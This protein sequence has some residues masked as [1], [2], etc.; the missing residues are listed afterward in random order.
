[1]PYLKYITHSNVY[2]FAIILLAVSLPVSVFGMSLAQ[3]ILVINWV[4]EGNFKHKLQVV[5]G[6]KTIWIF[7]LV[8]LVHLIG[9]IYTSWPEGFIG[10]SYNAVKDIRIKLPIL[11]LPLIIGTSESLSAK[12][13]KTILLLF[14]TVVTINSFISIS[15]LFGYTNHIVNDIRDISLFISHIRFALLINIAIFSLCYYLIFQKQVLSKLEKFLF[16][17]LIIW[18]LVFLFILQSLTGLIILL[19]CGY[20]HIVISVFFSK[21]VIYKIIAISF[22]VLLPV[23]LFISSVAVLQDFLTIDEFNVKL[24]DKSTIKGSPYKH[25]T[26]NLQI[27][28]G[29]WVGSYICEKELEESWNRISDFKYNGKDRKGQ[30][31]KYTLI[32]YLTSMNLRKDT[33]GVNALD[34]SDIIMIEDG[35]SNFIFKNKYSLYPRIYQTIWEVDLYLRGGS[36]GGHSVAQRIEYLKASIGIIKQNIWFGVGTGDAQMAFNNQY[37]EMS[38]KLKVEYRHRA[39]NQFVTFVIT[40]GLIGAII[41]LFAMFYPIFIEKGYKDFLFLTFIIIAVFSML[42]EDTLETQP[43]VSFFAFFYSLFLFSKRKKDR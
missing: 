22:V 10:D 9:L 31:T 33:E 1:M 17:V 2:Y 35:Y 34:K 27:E 32:R 43:G 20:I 42:N 36:P 6:R 3:I 28:N 7:L 29:H 30:M 37:E 8:F 18:L 12:Q 14:V 39:H 13:L 11:L 38:S 26:N 16:P 23:V 41:I 24:L 19:I 4:W 21:K 15:V 25:D 5:K 40:F